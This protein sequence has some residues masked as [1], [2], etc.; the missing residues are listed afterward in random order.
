M[1]SLKS[2]PDSFAFAPVVPPP[3][4][5]VRWHEPVSASCQAGVTVAR[6]ETLTMKLPEGLLVWLEA[7]AKRARQPK[8]ALVGEILRQHQQRQHPS[9]LDL[10]ANL[11]GCAESGLG[12]VA[13]NKKHFTSE[14]SVAVLVCP[15]GTSGR[16]ARH[17]PAC[18]SPPRPLRSED[19]W[20]PQ[21]SLL[22]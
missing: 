12:D 18:R 7:E 19:S 16:K 4:P 9:A 17:L 10:T 20:C 11:C 1:V 8:S 6:M 2:G 5:S 15:P 21:P 13:C 3:Q 22:C 14:P